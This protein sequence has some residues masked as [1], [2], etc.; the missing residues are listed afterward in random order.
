MVA[1][2]YPDDEEYYAK[3]ASS[4]QPLDPD[5][6]GIKIAKNWLETCAAGDEH[7]DCYSFGKLTPKLP[8]RLIDVGP[9]GSKVPKIIDTLGPIEPSLGGAPYL[10]LSHC[11]GDAAKVIKTTSANLAQHLS[12]IRWDS[13][14]RTFQDAITVTQFL[15]YR[16]L[17]IDSLCIVQDDPEDFQAQCSLMHVIYL[18]SSCMIAASDG[19]CGDDG[20]LTFWTD[21]PSGENLN[22]AP[23]ARPAF[24]PLMASAIK[25]KRDPEEM[26]DV[27]PP[28]PTWQDLISGP[29]NQR[30][31]TCQ[32]RQLAP[33]ILHYTRFGV[34]W[35]CRR[36]IGM[37]DAMQLCRRESCHFMEDVTDADSF[38]SWSSA[39]EEDIKSR[40][41]SNW[42]DLNKDKSEMDG[43]KNVVDDTS[44]HG[45]LSSSSSL[46]ESQ[47]DDEE[48]ELDNYYREEASE[49]GEWRI[50]DRIDSQD[51]HQTMTQ[52]RFLVEDY[53]RRRLTFIS[54]KL[55]ALAGIAYMVQFFWPGGGLYLAGIWE[56]E[57]QRQLFWQTLWTE[58][59]GE[60]EP[61]PRKRI[62]EFPSWSWMSWDGP[63][64]FIDAASLVSNNKLE[65]TAHRLEFNSS[66][67]KAKPGSHQLDLV[68]EYLDRDM[69]DTIGPASSWNKKDGEK[70]GF[71]IQFDD[72]NV[73]PSAIAGIS[74]RFLFLLK[75]VDG[76]RHHVGL[77]LQQV[78]GGKFKR[79]GR[80]TR[81]PV[82][83]KAPE[84]I[85][86]RGVTSIV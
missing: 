26:F 64:T 75:E 14:S 10:T 60:R 77:T 85:L 35:E 86:T 79:I 56:A 7:R 43:E 23:D 62:S 2:I 3:T 21:S 38:P 80:F 82:N 13:L 16:Y 84:A 46:A 24:S 81:V 70:S 1:L 50:L 19:T 42:E 6:Y 37:G 4:R 33:R 41:S 40:N 34:L 22:L 29:L 47:E 49:Y 17:W 68:G 54:D 69:P 53:S 76:F 45:E 74:I 11:W 66:D 73:E 72:E 36:C 65:Y 83:H 58:K 8:S 63:V 27:G 71:A 15:G 12:L 52:W 31:W 61:R 48:D 39:D 30:G 5:L 28:K 44:Q 78:E 57:L 59:E 67:W 55:F 32:E 20:F 51:V 18:F 25:R 9:Q